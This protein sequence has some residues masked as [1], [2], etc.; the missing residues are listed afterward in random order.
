[1][2]YIYSFFFLMSFI[3][4]CVYW[5][6]LLSHLSF[7][8]KWSIGL[9]PSRVKPSYLSLA[10]PCMSFPYNSTVFKSHLQ[11]LL[12]LPL[13]F[14]LSY[15]IL[16]VIWFPEKGLQVIQ[17]TGIVNVFF[18]ISASFSHNLIRWHLFSSW[19]IIE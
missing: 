17:F 6:I 7:I 3:L 15:S 9:H 18:G 2:D 8:L 19:F 13:F 16:F 4:K 14:F 5:H 10:V 1:M 12:D 11:A